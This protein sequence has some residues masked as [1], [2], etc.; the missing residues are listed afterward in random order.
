MKKSLIEEFNKISF[1]RLKNIKMGSA[2]S[3]DL[4]FHKQWGEKD[5]KVLKENFRK[6]GDFTVSHNDKA[7]I[8]FVMSNFNICRHDMSKMFDNVTK[9]IGNKMVIK[10]K[11]YNFTEENRNLYLPA[12]WL[13]QMRNIRLT[14]MQKKIIA[15]HMYTYWCEAQR[16]L[17]VIQKQRDSLRLVAVFDDTC[18]IESIIAQKCRQW[19][20]KTST[21]KHAIIN[22]SFHYIEYRYS[23]VDYFLA[24]GAYMR[25]MAVRMGMPKEKIKVL[26]PLFMLEPIR[27]M[28][29][30][31]KNKIFGVLTR[32]TCNEMYMDDNVEMIHMANKLAEK[33]GY[34]YILRVHPL[35]DKTGI[36]KKN[37]DREVYNYEAER[38]TNH[39]SSVFEFLEQVEFVL[40][41]NTSAFIETL[42][43]N[44]MAFR[45]I[46]EKERKNDVCAGI[47]FGRVSCY[48]QLEK[49]FE[50]YMENDNGQKRKSIL[51][52]M[53]NMGDVRENYIKFFKNFM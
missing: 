34:T 23:T 48:E 51:R 12:I 44:K 26:G 1:F 8:C 14:K 24:W 39:N 3:I 31:N 10:G 6:I 33:Y 29:Q 41:G 30:Q 32:G 52:Y 9:L 19:N 40:C 38:F 37:I 20:I 43:A 46:P 42:L 7:T 17:Q 53:L 16:V 49:S 27:H 47:P 11:K 50:D 21:C 22:G 2:L 18:P 13:Y 35:D 36:Y 5:Y 45:F 25:D 28:A 4:I 15:M